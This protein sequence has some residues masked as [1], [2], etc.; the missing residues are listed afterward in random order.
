M[1]IVKAKSY[2]E[3]KIHKYKKIFSLFVSL[4]LSLS[5]VIASHPF[6]DENGDGINDLGE[7]DVEEIT[8]ED[9]GTTSSDGF[10]YDV[11]LGWEHLTGTYD[12]N[13]NERIDELHAT[14]TSGDYEAATETAEEVENTLKIIEDNV[15]ATEAGTTTISEVATSEET[16]VHEILSVEETFIEDDGIK[17]KIEA[18]NSELTALVDTG[19]ITT[20]TAGEIINTVQLT[21]AETL[22]VIEEQKEKLIEQIATTSETSVLEVELAV[23][24]EE[25]QAGL[26]EE[27]KEEITSTEIVVLETAIEEIKTEVVENEKEGHDEEAHAMKVLLANAELHLQRAEQAL[28]TGNTGKAFGQFTSAEHLTLNADRLSD[29]TFSE[30]PKEE[31]SKIEEL[32]K[33][34]EE[35]REEIHEETASH[36]KEWEEHKD[37]LLTKYP[38]KKEFLESEYE[39]AKKVV[40]L[41]DKLAGKY[42][43]KY[44][45]LKAEGKTQEKIDSEL[46]SIF[47]QEFQLAYGEE[48]TPPGFIEEK[49][50]VGD[51]VKIEFGGGFV[52]GQ[53]Y[54][55]PTNNGNYKFG[56]NSY[57]FVSVLG[58]THTFEYPEG[59]DPKTYSRGDESF[60]YESDG[61]KY[62]YSATGYLIT[63]PDGTKEEHAYTPGKYEAVGGAVIN[64]NP[65]GFDCKSPEGKITKFEFNP[66]YDNYVAEDGK[67]YVPEVSAH[68]EETKYDATDKKYEYS[69][70]GATWSYDPAKD[71]WV[72]STGETHK[73]VAQIGAP[74]GHEEQGSYNTEHGEKW[75]YDSSSGKWK[76]SSTGK[77]YAPPPS[78]YYA[79]D[80]A[81]G[82]Y[83]DT[84][85]NVHESSSFEHSGTTWSYDKSTGKWAS[86]TG[87]T[88]DIITGQ[89]TGETTYSTGGY[90]EAGHLDSYGHAYGGETTIHSEGYYSST[91]TYTGGGTTSTG[92]YT[93]G[94]TTTS[95]TGGTTTTSGGDTTGE[96]APTHSD[97]GH[98]G[99]IIYDYKETVI[100]NPGDTKKYRLF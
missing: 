27:H 72:S 11:E 55:D 98:T 62:E 40:D 64:H 80:S 30:L 99:H 42:D 97:G 86:N 13:L 43:D 33:T 58:G 95:T 85:G 3:Y 10:L 82:K 39:Q 84:E 9:P 63:K 18:I 50:V 81:T 92:T 26:H 83:V 28:E 34:G 24:E 71:L 74:I 31:T 46:T 1:K 68:I 29:K 89:S 51:Q 78:A 19:T 94:E 76:E 88:Y 23:T 6:V 73:P 37:L 87:E 52:E 15:E 57:T 8:F 44:E 21:T 16:P 91:G 61:Y 56:D 60:E 2:Q 36:V 20:E 17:D 59:Y 41:T 45:K 25:E 7:H 12:N 5:L 48:Y 67:V 49:T 100:I 35:I 70:A 38:E 22:V 32:E 77:E 4:L 75:I 66:E 79:Y 93:G 47:S 90:Y 96:S 53:E 54:V 69:H 65:T 14:I